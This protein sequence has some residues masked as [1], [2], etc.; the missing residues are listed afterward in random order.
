MDAGTLN[1]AISD[2]C[3]VLTV[4]VVDPENR[5][6]WSYEPAPEATAPEKAAA[7][8]VIATIP[9]DPL[10]A[11]GPSEFIYRFTTAEYLLLK[12]KH[13]TD[14]EASDASSVRIWDIVIGSNVMDMNSENATLLKSEL[15]TDGILTQQRADEIFGTPFAS[16]TRSK[17]WR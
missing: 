17:K 9:I 4:T 15:V 3:P 13:T 14:L 1:L 5:G 8:N 10:P 2:V 11:L 6:T 12:Q 7:D 16:G